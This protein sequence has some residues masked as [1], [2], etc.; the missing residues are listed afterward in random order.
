MKVLIHSNAPWV[1]SGY[2][3]QTAHLVDTFQKLG[4]DVAVSCFSGLS[5]STMTRDGVL[6]L[7]NGQYE[8]GV[9]V[10]PG[11]IQAV[12]P[13]LVL[14]LMDIWKLGPIRD[15]LK[16]HNV[17]MWVPVDCS[18]LSKLDRQVLL[19]TGATPVAMAPHGRKALK[20]AGFNPEYVP[21][22]LDPDVFKPL[23]PDTRA[24]YREAMGLKDRFVVGICSANNDTIRKGFPEQFEAFRRFQKRNP[25]AFLLVHSV[26]NS[27]RGLKL[28]MLAYD[29]GIPQDAIRFTD[30]YAQLSGAFDESLMADWYGVLDVLSCASYA[31]AFGVPLIEAQACGTPVV[32]TNAS[33]MA[34]L[35]GPGWAV[36]G[37]EFWNH[38]HGAWW[39]R[40]DVAAIVRAYEKAKTHA[41]SLREK[42]ATFAA[43]F[44][45]DQVAEKYWKPA[46]A[47]LEA[48][49]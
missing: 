48:K 41:A 49:K 44:T 39:Q 21:H 33:A 22:A 2:G 5:G 13:D 36:S 27:S 4:H 29:L 12:Q 35:K 17:A 23:D 18:P 7:P 24:E 14:T 6:Y 34:D 31:E 8:Y 1:P 38:V 32:T 28:D 37:H 26:A 20:E 43:D 3:K 30:T 11:H 15:E 25:E 40:P 42:A 16:G 19:D 46:L 47:N 10:L 45:V 9:D